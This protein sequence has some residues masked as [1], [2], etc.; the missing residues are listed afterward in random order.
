[1]WHPL[2]TYEML[3]V[4]PEGNN[5]YYMSNEE[6]EFLLFKLSP[7]ASYPYEQNIQFVIID[8]DTSQMHVA[9]LY[10]YCYDIYTSN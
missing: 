5:Y 7:V 8:P 1:M 2:A 3:S 9:I 10:G 4:E 6:L